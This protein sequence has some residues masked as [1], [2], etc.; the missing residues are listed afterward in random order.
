MTT[1]TYTKTID[2]TKQPTITGTGHN[3]TKHTTREENNLE[4]DRIDSQTTSE[5]E[6]RER[7]NSS[8]II[9]EIN[10]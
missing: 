3:R 1:I 9:Y 4:R 7:C 5:R 2:T 10:K 6:S 8:S